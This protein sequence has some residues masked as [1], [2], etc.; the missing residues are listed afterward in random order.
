MRRLFCVMKLL[1]ERTVSQSCFY[2]YRIRFDPYDSSCGRLLVKGD[3]PSEGG[4][5]AHPV[6]CNEEDRC[7]ESAAL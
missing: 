5:V 7:L 3:C 1:V 6:G 2:E 4:G